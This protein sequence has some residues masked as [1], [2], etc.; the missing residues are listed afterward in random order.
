M[1]V[2]AIAVTAGG[3]W[4][5]VDNQNAQGK[6]IAEIKTT[7]T[8][9][10]KDQDNKREQLGKDF[11]ASN[12]KIADKVGDL[13]AAVLVQ[14]ATAKTMADTLAHISDQLST[15]IVTPGARRK[16]NE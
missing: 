11:L 13:N 2:C 8:N 9:A 4:F 10:T 14:Q 6:D 7:V 12:Q 1:V 16:A 5:L 15:A 3:Y